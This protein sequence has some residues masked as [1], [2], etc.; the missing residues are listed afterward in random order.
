MTN[1]SYGT[2]SVCFTDSQDE[3]FAESELRLLLREK[4]SRKPKQWKGKIV[5]CGDRVTIFD[6]FTQTTIRSLFSDSSKRIGNVLQLR[7]GSFLLVEYSGTLHKYNHNTFEIITNDTHS[8]ADRQDRYVLFEYHDFVI[9]ASHSCLVFDKSLQFIKSLPYTASHIIHTTDD[10]LLISGHSDVILLNSNLE[11]VQS[12]RF[13]DNLRLVVEIRP[14]EFLFYGDDILC[15]DAN[16]NDT[17]EVPLAVLS[18]LITLKDGRL[19]YD[20]RE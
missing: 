20:T 13:T 19:V 6:L 16:T 9:A 11:L 5:F 1:V 15:W 18:F 17:T 14:K 10:N 3:S 12:V 7:D 8:I 4:L 2:V